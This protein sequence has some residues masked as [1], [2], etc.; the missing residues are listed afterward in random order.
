[1]LKNRTL[2]NRTL[3]SYSNEFAKRIDG[4]Q[5]RDITSIRYYEYRKHLLADSDKTKLEILSTEERTDRVL[6]LISNV[7]ERINGSLV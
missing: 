5:G 2:G 7:K 4:K 1:M 3:A 6:K